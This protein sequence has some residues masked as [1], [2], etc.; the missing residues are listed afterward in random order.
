VPARR[1]SALELR[2]RKLL[3]FYRAWSAEPPY[4][5][6]LTAL[7]VAVHALVLDQAE[8]P[9]AL[10]PTLDA[11]VAEMN[12]PAAAGADLWHSI[13]GH[14]FGAGRESLAFR[15]DTP[16]R[17]TLEATGGVAVGGKA[18]IE[19]RPA[20]RLAPTQHAD[21]AD[22]ERLGRRL[23]RAMLGWTWSRIAAFRV[24][25]G[26][27]SATAVYEAV[28]ECLAGR[29]SIKAYYVGDWDPSG[30]HMS[31]EDLPGRLRTYWAEQLQTRGIPGW[32]EE[33]EFPEIVLPGSR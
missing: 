1:Y 7:A 6:R 9:L 12:L 33:D 16:R 22:L 27:G 11:F 23:V 28:S 24:M 26:Y 31:E 19:R 4:Q 5:A 17:Y 2:R 30:L 32:K 25:H 13:R 3:A 29:K 21:P 10:G 18:I 14:A 15:I 8:V 20:G